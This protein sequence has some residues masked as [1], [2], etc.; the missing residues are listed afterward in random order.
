VDDPS[1]Y[2]FGIEE[3]FPW[4]PLLV[5]AVIPL[6]VTPLLSWLAFELTDQNIE[7]HA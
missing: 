7:R 4:L 2:R 3:P 5:G 6:I 1:R